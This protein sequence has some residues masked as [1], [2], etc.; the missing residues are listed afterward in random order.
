MTGKQFTFKQVGH[1]FAVIGYLFRAFTSDNDKCDKCEHID[2]GVGCMGD[3]WHGYDKDGVLIASF[4]DWHHG[5]AY[6]DPNGIVL[7]RSLN[8]GGFLLC[9]DSCNAFDFVCSLSR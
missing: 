1:A 5:V 9:H 7:W 8:G 4:C 3:L 6:Q 2:R